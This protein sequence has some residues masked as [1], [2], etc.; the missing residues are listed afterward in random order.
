MQGLSCV[1]FSGLGMFSGQFLSLLFTNFIVSGF[2]SSNEGCLAGAFLVL[3]ASFFF[4]NGCRSSNDF[5]SALVGT[6][7]GLVPPLA[8][9]KEQFTHVFVPVLNF[10]LVR[11]CPGS[12]KRLLARLRLKVNVLLLLQKLIYFS[13][14]VKLLYSNYLQNVHQL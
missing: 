5:F 7:F 1:S 4:G 3:R 13:K 10:F 2:V 12:E 11:F 8:S 9:E 14:V 6:L